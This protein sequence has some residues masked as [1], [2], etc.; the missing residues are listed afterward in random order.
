MT[1]I[2][3]RRID[4]SRNMARFYRLDVQPNLFGEWSL[5]REWGRIGRAGRLRL[6]PYPTPSEACAALERQ[7]R[8][9]QRRGYKC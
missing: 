1:A 6:V 8:L 3:L 7:Q 4:S 9:K 2:V 5:V